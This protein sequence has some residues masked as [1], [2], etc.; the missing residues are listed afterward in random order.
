M[1]TGEHHQGDAAKD[2]AAAQAAIDEAIAKAVKAQADADKARADAEAAQAAARSARAK[3]ATDERDNLE[4]DTSLA[5]EQRDATARKKIAEAQKATVAAQRDQVAALIPDFSKSDRGSLEVKG[6]G[7]LFAAALGRGALDAA[8]RSLAQQAS[9]SLA[10]TPRVLVTSDAELSSSHAAYLDVITGLDQLSNAAGALLAQLT[11][12]QAPANAPMVAAAVAPAMAI[13]GAIAQALPGLVSLFSAHRTVTTA[14]VTTDDLA[15][16]AATVNAL[17]TTVPGATL[18]HDGV[19]L[20]PKGSVHTKLAGLAEKRQQ[21]SARKLAL[22]DDKAR[23]SASLTEARGIVSDLEQALA[24]SPSDATIRQ[25]LVAARGNVEQYEQKLGA[26]SARLGL[27]DSALAAIDSFVTSL[28]AVPE[29]GNRSPLGLAAMREGLD[30]S[31]DATAGQPRFTHVLVV[32]GG[33]GSAQ[34]TVDD[35]PFWFK[36]QFS[37]L[38]TATITF[39]LLDTA[40]NAIVAAGNPAG[41]AAAT[42]KIGGD[43]QVRLKETQLQS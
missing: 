10:G 36:D 16:A 24:A 42:G 13:G 5:G 11:D 3:A 32:K 28:T 14:P 33:V 19:R 34:Q 2:P 1:G 18:V 22:E 41:S 29:G 12:R 38:A 21:L 35:R 6:D 31:G 43:F 25:E 37:V 9:A 40:T 15:A 27:I 30:A 4:Q 17:R 20:L 7:V 26:E 23:T 8:A 39:M